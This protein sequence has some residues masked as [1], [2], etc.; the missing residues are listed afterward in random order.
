MFMV[1][2][3]GLSK[4]QHMQ[5]GGKPARY[6]IDTWD[7]QS[8]ETAVILARPDSR[9]TMAVMER[10]RRLTGWLRGQTDNPEAPEG[11]ELNNPWKVSGVLDQL[12]G[13]KM[14]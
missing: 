5:N 2:G 1:T 6:G 7:K 10:D 11:F 8:T 13:P 9:L 4:I 3:A 14:L 12:Y